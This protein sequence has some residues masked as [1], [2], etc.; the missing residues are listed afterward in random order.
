MS[1]VRTYFKTA[2]LLTVLIISA[3]VSWQWM[4]SSIVESGVRWLPL[5][6]TSLTTFFL[7]M[8]IVFNPRSAQT[9]AIPYAVLQGGFLGVVSGTF[10]NSYEGIVGQAIFTTL[11]V[12]LAVFFGYSIGILKASSTFARIIITAMLGLLMFSLLSW[13]FSL[14][15]LSTPVIYS[16]GNW[17]IAFSIAV[18]IVAA[19]SLVLDFDFIDTAAKQ[20]FPKYF[21]WYAAYGLMVGLVWLYLEILQLLA[22]F[23]ARNS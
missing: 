13:I 19:L 9:L 2:I 23:A 22:K 6:I 1:V 16:Y 20:K 8:V 14:F 10:A 11:A 15:S 3:A 17:G 4:Q 7:G 12:F 18:V 21:E 5:W